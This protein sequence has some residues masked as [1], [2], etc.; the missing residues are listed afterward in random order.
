MHRVNTEQYKDKIRACM[1][2][3]VPLMAYGAHGIGK[4]EIPGA[5]VFP[6][7]AEDMGREFLD[8]TKASYDQKMEAIENPE[9]I[10]AFL[11]LRIAQYDP[12][13]LRGLPN[14]ANSEMLE[15]IPYSWIVYFTKAKAAGV[16]FF[17]E[18][19]LAP[20]VVS[21]AAYQIIHDRRISDRKLAEDVWVMAAGNRIGVDKAH[22]FEMPDPLKDRFAE[23]EVYCPVKCW[24]TWANENGVN[25]NLVAFVN[26]KEIYL[27]RNVEGDKG[28]TPRGIVRASKLIEDMDIASNE[29]HSL[30][31]IAA[32]EAFAT[33]FQAYTKCYAKLNWKSIFANPS[34][35]KDLSVSEVWAVTGGIAE[36][37]LKDLNKADKQKLFNQK[38]EVLEYM[39][40]DF[41]I[42]AMRMMRESKPKAFKDLIR[43]HPNFQQLSKKYSKFLAPSS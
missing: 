7:I 19:N 32:G 5:Q 15:N 10:W 26:W 29:A 42:L 25:P 12:T 40:E 8:W 20:P 35:V 22:L 11:D 37:F 38:I 36:L 6:Q 17:D 21:G 1:K 33:E 28:S 30:I 13:E 23:C 16:I 27:H 14:M 43:Q 41:A 24:T 9:K 18:I 31:S 4:S 34:S 2:A 3:D 39:Q